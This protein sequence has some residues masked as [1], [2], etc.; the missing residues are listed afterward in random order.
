M[1]ETHL[2][3]KTGIIIIIALLLF[4]IYKAEH[5]KFQEIRNYDSARDPR[6][7]TQKDEDLMKHFN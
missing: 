7:Y 6:G 3:I 4:I 2:F 5:F 1:D